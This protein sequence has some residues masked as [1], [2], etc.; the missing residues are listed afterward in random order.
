MFSMS[1]IELVLLDFEI[2]EWMLSLILAEIQRWVFVHQSSSDPLHCQPN[3]TVLL[4]SVS[5]KV[6]MADADKARRSSSMHPAEQTQRFILLNLPSSELSYFPYWKTVMTFRSSLFHYYLC[7]TGQDDIQSW[8]R[9]ML[10][11]DRD[12]VL[13]YPEKTYFNSHCQIVFKVCLPSEF[14]LYHSLNY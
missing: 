9:C 6:L 3:S 7:S 13:V 12:E 4:L 1:I 5:Q 8:T 11:E 10:E 14:W 2:L